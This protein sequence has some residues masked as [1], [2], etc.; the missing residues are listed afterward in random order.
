MVGKGKVEKVITSFENY[1]DLSLPGSESYSVAYEGLTLHRDGGS[2]RV[3][4]FE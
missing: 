4:R 3:R 1:C 2:I